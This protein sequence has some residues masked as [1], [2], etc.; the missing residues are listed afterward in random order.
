M[1]IKELKARWSKTLERMEAEHKEML[2]R[3]WAADQQRSVI[4]MLKENIH[5]LDLITERLGAR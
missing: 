5:D 4:M 2:P 3:S 1:T